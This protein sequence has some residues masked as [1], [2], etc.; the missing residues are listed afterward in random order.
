[1]LTIEPGAH[2]FTGVGPYNHDVAFFVADE[3]PSTLATAMA[4]GG[5]ELPAGSTVCSIYVHYSPTDAGWGLSNVSFDVR[6]R[7]IG[8]IT[9]ENQLDATDFL[10]HPGSVYLPARAMEEE[11]V[12]SVNGQTVSI[13]TETSP[14]YAE[15]LRI[16]TAC[17]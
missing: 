1:M 5:V 17:P 3:G 8:I 6:D 11:D 14:R 13:L 7:I 16:I 4:V 2:D 15:T 9:T 12:L 10:G